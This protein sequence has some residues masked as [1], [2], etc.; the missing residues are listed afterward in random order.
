M[1]PGREP[2]DRRRIRRHLIRAFL[3]AHGH[4]S[5]AGRGFRDLD[6]RRDYCAVFDDATAW[7]HDVLA[8]LERVRSMREAR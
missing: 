6:G 8:E 4:A 2:V 3:V 5:C 1:I 7:S